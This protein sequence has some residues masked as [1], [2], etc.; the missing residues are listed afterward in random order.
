MNKMTVS[1]RKVVQLLAVLKQLHKQITES[2]FDSER[3]SLVERE[4]DVWFDEQHFGF[5]VAFDV[6]I[7]ANA[8][9]ERGFSD[10]NSNVKVEIL[11]CILLLEDLD[12][13]VTNIINN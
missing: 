3:S 2:A 5:K 7:Y 9:R 4:F 13:D 6:E 1:E 10:N 11:E 12:L 8:Y